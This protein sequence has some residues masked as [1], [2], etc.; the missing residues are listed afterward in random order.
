M[1]LLPKVATKTKTEYADRGTNRFRMYVE[2]S[3]KGFGYTVGII[4]PWKT[5]GVKETSEQIAQNNILGCL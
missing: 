1:Y 2:H 3:K 4:G 5:S